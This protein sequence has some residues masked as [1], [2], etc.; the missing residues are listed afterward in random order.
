MTMTLFPVNIK[1]LNNQAIE[2]SNSG[3]SHMDNQY[4]PSINAYIEENLPE[5]YNKLIISNELTQFCLFYCLKA[6]RY[7]QSYKHES[8]KQNLQDFQANELTYKDIFSEI[9]N[10]LKNRYTDTEEQ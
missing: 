8:S 5:F 7:E 6:A 2:L 1:E 9:E 3:I 10:D 4:G